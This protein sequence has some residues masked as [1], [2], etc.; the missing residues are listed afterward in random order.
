MKTF[1]KEIKDIEV[2]R[3]TLEEY[4]FLLLEMMLTTKTEA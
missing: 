3:P 4:I 2:L 1:H